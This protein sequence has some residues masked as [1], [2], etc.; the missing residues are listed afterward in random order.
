MSTC[1]S[2]WSIRHSLASKKVNQHVHN[3]KGSARTLI[4][5]RTVPRNQWRN[6]F[7]CIEYKAAKEISSLVSISYT[8][9]RL[10]KNCHQ[11]SAMTQSGR[12]GCIWHSGATRIMVSQLKYTS[13]SQKF[14][15]LFKSLEVRSSYTPRT[16]KVLKA[17]MLSRTHKH[18]KSE[19][20][21]I[22]F[23]FCE[24]IIHLSSIVT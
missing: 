19:Q 5:S 11:P 10:C 12:C 16:T 20:K 22:I 21:T 2:C 6:F 23:R 24:M 18:E 4:S 1:Q 3:T 14:C 17:A 7:E 15:S 8:P 13:H 9:F